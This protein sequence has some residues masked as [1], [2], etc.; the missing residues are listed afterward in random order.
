LHE[1]ELRD[2][3]ISIINKTAARAWSIDACYIFDGHLYVPV[4]SP[5]LATIIDTLLR[6]LN[7]LAAGFHTLPTL[8]T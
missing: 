2:V 6:D 4:A 1:A 8:A 3:T 5:L 7:H